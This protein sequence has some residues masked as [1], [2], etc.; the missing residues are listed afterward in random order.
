MAF[1]TTNVIISQ[2]PDC[3]DVSTKVDK[4]DGS[5]KHSSPT[6]RRIIF[7]KH[8]DKTDTTYFI[9]L[10][11]YGVTLAIGDGV[12]LLLSDSSKI[13][14][15][16][17]EIKTSV[18]DYGYKYSALLIVTRKQIYKIYKNPITDFRLYVFDTEIPKENQIMYKTFLDCMLNFF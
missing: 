1:L 17:A 10:T 3:G 4:F 11:S 9:H 7:V 8:I 6:D 12:T 16:S 15:P 2:V 13:S 5:K 18:D 14:F